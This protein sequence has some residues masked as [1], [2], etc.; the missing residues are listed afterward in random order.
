MNYIN[1]YLRNIKPYKVASHKVWKVS[2][3]ERNS[4]LKLDWNESTC[5]P[6]PLVRK[7]IA[8]FVENNCLNL[9]PPTYNEELHNLLSEYV[10]LPKDYIQYFASSDALHEYVSRVYVSPGDPVLIL[11]PSYDNFRLTMQSAGASVSFFEPGEDFI[12]D[13][14]SFEE[15]IQR[16][17]PALVYICNPN[18]PTGAVLDKAFL[19]KLINQNPDTLFLID[20]AYIEFAEEYT[21]KDFVLNHDN[22]LISRTMSKAFGLANIRFGYLIASKKNINAISNIRNPK[23]VTS[24]A[25]EAVIG[26]LQDVAYMKSYVREVKRAKDFFIS[27]INTVFNDRFRAFHSYGNFVL[28]NCGDLVNKRAVTDFLEQNNIYVRAVNQ[29]E[30]VINCIRITIGTF[31]QM[32][33]VI[34]AL[35][36]F[37]KATK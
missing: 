15:Q 11:W 18:N 31:D 12:L 2:P 7:R 19:S 9:Y 10:G 26:A 25:Q 34:N 21:C 30:S 20:E 4:V 14:K 37:C 3:E 16:T 36:M 22:V 17:N 32:K 28:I 33:L 8:K 6:S 1:R 27:T 29:S 35:H 24:F 23:N 13:Y 5:E